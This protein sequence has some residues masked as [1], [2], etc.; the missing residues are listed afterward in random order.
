MVKK[1]KGKAPPRQDA[2]PA[3]SSSTP[4]HPKGKKGPEP[5]GVDPGILAPPKPTA[6]QILGGSSWTGK[7]PVNLFNEHCQKQKWHQ[8]VYD[9]KKTP[10]G[11]MCWVGLSAR[12]PKTQEIT[13][14]DSFKIPASHK[15][16]LCKETPL[17]A[18]NY[19]ATYALFRVCSMQN[20][21]QV[22]PPD[23][24]ILWRDFASLKAEDVKE[25]REWMYSADPFKTHHERETAK[26]AVEKKRQEARA[27]A[28]KAKSMPGASGLALR[29]NDAA[30]G[31]GYNPMKGWAT[32]PKI[33]MG[34][35]A[36]A[37]LESLLRRSSTWNPYGIEIPADQRKKIV[38]ELSKTGF[39]PSHAEE[40]TSYCKDKEETLEWLMIHVP[41]DDLPSWALPGGYTAGVSVGAT[42]L[43][44]EGAIK[45]LAESGYNAELCTRAY[46]DAGGDE[47]KA[48]EVLQRVLLGRANEPEVT[49]E[50]EEGLFYGTQEEH[51]EEETESLES[52]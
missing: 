9:M 12:D 22:L 28:E 17:E 11:F 23:F 32:A 49:P 13:K 20:R 16:L 15:H 6:K 52:V 2:S 44:R 27:A 47:G 4:P 41:E 43:K 10:D 37:Q 25:G 48:A 33:E 31:R 36:R 40:A 38:D 3:A 21:H 39:R 18:R 7:L 51:W 34:K 5:E 35:K 19:A 14:L 45:R 24:K 8:P 26:A 1:G 50:D 42:D 46:D 30:G 29:G